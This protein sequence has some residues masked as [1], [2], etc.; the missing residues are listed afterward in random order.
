MTEFC[1][2]ETPGGLFV[3]GNSKISG[4]RPR[5]NAFSLPAPETCPGS[6]PTCRRDCYA[7]SAQSSLPEV[8]REGYARNRQ[9]IERYHARSLLDDSHNRRRTLSIYD[10]S[11]A[12]AFGA[13]IRAHCQD[14][15]FRWHV[16]GDVFA[17]WYA[18]WI[19]EVAET[20]QP[21]R[22]WIYTRSLDW[23]HILA[24]F[25][26]NLTV[27]VSA[28][29]DNLYEAY[30]IARKHG[31]KLAYLWKGE[32]FVDLREVALRRGDI[33]LPG[34]GQRRRNGA[35][36]PP[37]PYRA[38]ICGADYFGQ[39]KRLRCGVCTKCGNPRHK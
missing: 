38:M 28:D 27:L 24:G 39:S 32:P 5:P 15:G 23:V 4:W 37:P 31:L 35:V 2:T 1:Y 26:P 25:A 9:M 13:W 30:P 7:H 20:S 6:T 19:V 34:Y 3:D 18:W 14:I 21:V 33:I 8:L 11:A 22:H 36:L 10:A 17:E 29:K 12:S 16:S